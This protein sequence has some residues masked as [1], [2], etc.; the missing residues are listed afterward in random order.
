[1]SII[2]DK[3]LQSARDTDLFKKLENYIDS[4]LGSSLSKFDTFPKYAPRSA[5]ARF[6]TRFE[7]FKQQLEIPGSIVEIGVAR[8]AS[9]MTWAQLSSIM[10]P[11]NFTRMIVG[12]DTF[13]GFPSTHKKDMIE[14]SSHLV[15][16]GGMQVEDGMMEDILQA[17]S[18]HDANRHLNHIEKVQ[19]VKGDI[20]KTLPLFIKNNPHLVISL[21]HLDVDLYEPTKLALELLVPRMPKGGIL[22]FDELNTKLFPGETMALLE[23]LGIASLNL[24]RFIWSTTTSYAVID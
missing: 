16:K 2:R 18:I 9:L 23:T 6:I 14:G 1:M 5:L 19:L 17:I 8:G 3:S 20:M 11:N 24:K 7:I 10:E 12:F 22:L 21:L 4:S 15:K 13:S